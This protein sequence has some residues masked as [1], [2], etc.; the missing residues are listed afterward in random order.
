MIVDSEIF[1]VTRGMNIDEKLQYT[2]QTKKSPRYKEWVEQI[3]NEI[4]G[5]LDEKR[6]KQ[7]IIEL[8]KGKFQ[9]WN[10]SP[11]LQYCEQV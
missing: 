3:K 7:I 10:A 4:L 11:D 8:L 1:T 9:Q 6:Y 2:R 5:K